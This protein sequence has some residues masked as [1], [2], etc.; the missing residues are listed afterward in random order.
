VICAGYRGYM[1]KEYFDNYILRV[2]DVPLAVDFRWRPGDSSSHV[3]VRSTSWVGVEVALDGERE[4]GEAAVADDLPKL[5]FGFEHSGG[6]PAQA[7]VARLPALDV[8]RGA[9]DRS[10]SSTRMGWWIAAFASAIP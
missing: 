7:H 9:S 1:I 3:S 6:S 10:R 4:R 2:E 8:A 5:P